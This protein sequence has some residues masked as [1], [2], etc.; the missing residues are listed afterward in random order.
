MSA[1]SAV[2]RDN[3]R[4]LYADILWWG[5]LSGSTLS[6]LPIYLA[7]LDASSFEIGLLTAG[8]A[9]LSLLF[10]LPAGNWLDR[11]LLTKATF[12]ASLWH[13]VG[14]LLMVPLGWFFIAR[15]QVLAVL[16]IVLL[17]AIP[18]AVVSISFNAMFADLTPPDWRARV[19]GRRFA[20]YSISTTLTVLACGPLLDH[21]P[22]PA[23]YQI[24]LAIGALGAG[25][26]SYH[27][28]R[29]RP[30]SHPPE[31][32]DHPILDSASIDTFRIGDA[33]R[34][35]PGL[36]FLLRAGGK[37]LLRLDLLRGPFGP[38]LVAY[39]LFYAFQYVS[40][41]LF[42]L[43]FVQN[44][45]LSDGLISLGN[46]LFYLAMLLTSLSL[47]WVSSRLGHRKVLVYTA[48]LFCAYPLMIG[49]ARDI[50]LYLAASLVGGAV[51]G[52]LIGGLTNR[53]MERVPEDDRPAHM[54]LHNLALNLGV[55]VGSLAGPALM[56]AL[57][58]RI[59]ILIGAGLR[60]LAGVL[61]ARW[62]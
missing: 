10:S 2:Q 24:V 11:R 28:S 35:R 7:R 45:E 15:Q 36:R 18:G 21:L 14:Y 54:A 47:H 29:L 27:L 56:E 34:H 43:F 52:L 37:S 20:I 53:L 26:S 19:V 51:T 9:V 59:A 3:F 23:N 40:I 39:F 50:P 16:A 8:P 57:D 4:H 42:P 38:F 58:L 25:L 49:L 6:F 48:L 41:P 12:Q 61:L 33:L 5:V 30:T 31:R 13:R 32:V 17:T 60:L 1:L 44:L 55:L 22:F 62:G 46:A